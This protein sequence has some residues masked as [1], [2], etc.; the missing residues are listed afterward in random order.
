MTKEEMDQFLNQPS[1]WTMGSFY[2]CKE[3]PRLV[4]KPPR[5]LGLTVNLSKPMAIPLIIFTLAIII[6]PIEI[7]R[8]F[9]I[10]TPNVKHLT[11]VIS[12]IIML[13]VWITLLTK[14]NKTN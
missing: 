5:K 4:V 11:L 9:G 7:E 3:D 12:V 2:H 1:N 10:L 14:G 6:A 13:S 8:S